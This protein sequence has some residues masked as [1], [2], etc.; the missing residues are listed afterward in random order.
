RAA[1]AAVSQGPH[2]R[3]RARA[4]PRPPHRPRGVPL[5]ATL[6]LRDPA[7]GRRPRL[8]IPAEHDAREDPAGGR[9]AV[10]GGEHQPRSPLP[11]LA[12][13]GLAG[14]GRSGGERQP[15]AP[16][17]TG[18]GP[19]RGGRAG[20]PAGFPS[21]AAVDFEAPAPSAGRPPGMRRGGES[22]RAG[23][24]AVKTPSPWASVT[25]TRTGSSPRPAPS[26]KRN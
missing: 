18:S 21:P 17:G 1:R 7:G 15:R 14:G 11:L 3:G 20:A 8:R 13:G 16:V 12:R 23:A 9:P 22:A 19:V 10:G 6:D 25:R 26:P 5:G 24:G 4:A 2:G